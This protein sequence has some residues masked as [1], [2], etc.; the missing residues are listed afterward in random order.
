MPNLIEIITREMKLRNYSPR[1]ID[2]YVGV[3]KD[4]YARFKKPLREV[5]LEE[6]KE[7]L[8]SKNQ[9]GL[10]SQTMA[11]YANAINFLYTQIYQQKDFQKIRQPKRTKKLPIVLNR[12]EI[13]NLLA[14]TA[15]IKHRTMLAL[16]YAAGLRVSEIVNARARDIDLDEMTLT[17]R[18]GKGKKDRLTVLSPVLITDLKKMSAGKSPADYLFQSERGGGLTT[19]TAQKV[20]YACLAKAGIKKAATFHS[21]RHSF[22][23]HL[24]ENGTDVRYVQELLG[25]ANIR[26]TQI[27]TQVTNP[28]L[29][30]IKSPL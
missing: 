3:A 18:Q 19:A 26:T 4:M 24:L 29:K 27:Y 12:E 22:A 17:V 28:N 10:S 21:L 30:N 8:Y 25:H 20:F 16:A 7:Y 14:A 1:T 9:R 5:G 23:T 15:N 6:I 2:A 13:K 11:V